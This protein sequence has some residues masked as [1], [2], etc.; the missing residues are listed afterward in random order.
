MFARFFFHPLVAVIAL[1]VTASASAQF[2]QSDSY[3]FLQAVKDAKGEDIDKLLNKPATTIIN[4]RE[5]SSG[6][7]ALHIVAKRDDSTYMRY[8]LGR[9]ADPDLRDAA[10]NT[11][12]M[13]AVTAGYTDLI[14][15]LAAANAHVN[16][17]NRGGETST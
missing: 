3:Q 8:L 6:E 13:V 7:G 11:P 1:G 2:S 14:D 4:A 10:G 12:L 15:I 17:A 5:A 9:G 16:L